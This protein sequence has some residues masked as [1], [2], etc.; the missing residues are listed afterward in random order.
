MCSQY[1]IP[2]E[3]EKDGSF[4]ILDAYFIC[5]E[6]SAGDEKIK[7][8][9]FGVNILPVDNAPVRPRNVKIINFRVTVPLVNN[10]PGGG[11]MLK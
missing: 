9:K 4:P 6:D 3:A 8:I 10:V 2:R 7:V 1:I 5:K 11:E